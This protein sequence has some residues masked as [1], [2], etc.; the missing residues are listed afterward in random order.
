MTAPRE[1]IRDRDSGREPGRDRDLK[2][3]RDRGSASVE[4]VLIVPVVL[5]FLLLL[6]LTGRNYTAALAADALAHAAARSASLH[7]DRNEARNAAEQAVAASVG[8]W[9]R[10]C[11]EPA[12]RLRPTTEGNLRAMRAEVEC[13]VHRDDLRILEVSERRTVTGSAVSV[14]DVHREQEP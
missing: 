3:E 14:L 4:L 11:Q 10:A 9:G 1:R 2:R 13:T 6:A 8:G 7:T 5:A 12:V